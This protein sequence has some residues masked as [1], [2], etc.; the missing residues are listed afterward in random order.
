MN[1]ISAKGHLKD[2]KQ[3]APNGYYIT[4]EG[5][6]VVQTTKKVGLLFNDTYVLHYRPEYHETAVLFE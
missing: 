3:F 1:A 2:Q 4:N 6:F 5:E